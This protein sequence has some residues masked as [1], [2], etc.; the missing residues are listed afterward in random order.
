MKALIHSSHSI[1]TCVLFRLS[2]C[3]GELEDTS[4][5]TAFRVQSET[6][7]LPKFVNVSFVARKR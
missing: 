2:A 3:G 6:D 7:V 4:L 1:Y 5:L